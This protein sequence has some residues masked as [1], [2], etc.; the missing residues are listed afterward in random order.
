M[1]S[2]SLEKN[3]QAFFVDK[4]LHYLPEILHT[5]EMNPVCFFV[6]KVQAYY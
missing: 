5:H 3:L 1:L 6:I 2:E 4:S